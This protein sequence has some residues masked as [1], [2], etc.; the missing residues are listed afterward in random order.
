MARDNREYLRNSLAAAA[1]I[2]W[3]LLYT[4]FDVGII[5]FRIELVLG[6]DAMVGTLAP[7]VLAAV[8]AISVFVFARKNEKID[9]YGT[10]VVIEMRKVTW[11]TQKEVNGATIVVSIM[12]IIVSMILF[13]MDK[14]LDSLMS[15][16][17]S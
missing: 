11:P 2:L 9:K 8:I 6:A 5:F 12:T 7:A 3:Y 15:Y 17:L 1:V 16:A 13:M 10:E 4:A 14:S